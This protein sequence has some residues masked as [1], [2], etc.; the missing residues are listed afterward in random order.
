MLL[1][2][3]GL[4][5]L[6][7]WKLAGVLAPRAATA[8]DIAKA[9]ISGWDQRC[10][11][12]P[13]E[14]TAYVL[15]V[16][17]PVVLMCSA[18]V[19]LR[20]AR[21]FERE[22]RRALWVAAAAVVAQLLLVG[23]V[24]YALAYES[25]HP[26]AVP[27]HRVMPAQTVLVLC[28]AGW[29]ALR[30]QPLSWKARWASARPVLSK[31][32]GLAWLV[33]AGWAVVRLLEQVFTDR[34]AVQMPSVE[35]VHLP[36]QM[37]EFA[38]AANG[39]VPLVDFHSQYV[40]LLGLLL[41]PVFS[42]TGFNITTFTSA[43]AALSL[44]GFWLIYRVFV[45]VT[46]SSWVGL[47]LFVPWLGVSLVNMEPDGS[48]RMSAFSYYAVGPMRYLGVFVLAYGTA[49]YLAA[50]RLRRLVV[51]SCVAGLVVLNNLDF[52]VPAAAGLWASALLFPPP[53]QTGIRQALRASGVVVGGVALAFAVCWVVA[54]LTWGS[55]PHAGALI[56]YQ[57]AFAVLGFFM[58]R[59]PQVGLYW[60]VYATFMVAVLYAVFVRFSESAAA[61]PCRRRLSVGMLA[62]GGVAGLGS[63]AYYVGRSHPAVL[64]ALYPAWAFAA[65]LLA[66]RVVG[67][68]RAAE[69]SRRERGYSVYAIPAAAVLGLWCWLLPFVL[70]VPVVRGQISRLVYRRGGLV[71]LWPERAASLINTYVHKG[72]ATVIL[73]RDAHWLALRAS[74][75]NLCPFADPDSVLLKA[76]LDPVFESIGR[77][78]RHHRYVFGRLTGPI[79][80]RLSRD[81]FARVD[82][83]GDFEVWTDSG[84]RTT[85]TAL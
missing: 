62:Y 55:W 39:R 61:F 22:E 5:S 72:E 26:W 31:W 73:Y 68:V 54:R 51:V 10:A 49:Y 11:P 16:A 79:T 33:A 40:N 9:F 81:G 69:Q 47:L 24:G 57:R 78:P 28:L 3:A 77:L 20:L 80:E 66:H 29:L 48:G 63:G 44:V 17:V 70:E 42:L 37:G 4:T 25:E 7:V 32:P 56:E 6:A 34:D 76:Q 58:L 15:A 85:A 60:A 14:Q 30:W 65:A 83:N 43:M 59:M 36:F 64:V 12:E 41:R 27:L 45:R 35:G 8:A 21:V 84:S 74:V 75:N 46:G 38:A 67:D 50:P 13:V 1:P 2:I 52:G 19:L 82:A 53:G 18:I 71:D 23:C